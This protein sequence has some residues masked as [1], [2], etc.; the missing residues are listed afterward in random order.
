MT[1]EQ[2]KA[3][4][5]VTNNRSPK[6]DSIAIEQ[7]VN[8]ITPIIPEDM[9]YIASSELGLLVAFGMMLAVLAA[10]LKK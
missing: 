9:K 7:P 2:Q 3:I 6:T 4:T 1:T 5:Q 10:Q 8:P